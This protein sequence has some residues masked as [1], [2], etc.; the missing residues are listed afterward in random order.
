MRIPIRPVSA[1]DE[2]RPDFL[3]ILPWNLRHEI[4]AQMRHTADW[5]C[6]MI[7]PIPEVHVI[8]P[9]EAKP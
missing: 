7:V 5:G 9:S 2:V 6:K 1:I 3:L 8:D 4:A